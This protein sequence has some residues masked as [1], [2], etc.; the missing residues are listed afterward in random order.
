LAAVAR[1]GEGGSLKD[2]SGNNF[3]YGFCEHALSSF[4]R[5]GE[6]RRVL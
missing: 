3:D 5:T 1:K 2:R 6:D 4:E